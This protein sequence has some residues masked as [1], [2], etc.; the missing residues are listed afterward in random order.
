VIQI[1]HGDTHDELLKLP[2]ESVQTVVT[3]PPYLGLR[4]YGVKGQIGLEKT[5][6]DYVERLVDVFAQVGRVLRKDGTLWVNLGDAYVDGGRGNDAHTGSTLEG[7]RD[8]QVESRKTRVREGYKGLPRKN[9]LGMP[10]RVAFEMQEQGWILRSSVVWFKPNPMPESVYDRP[11]RA[12]E[13]VFLFSKNNSRPLLWRAKDTG[14]WSKRPDLNETLD[15]GGVCVRRWRG[16]DYY[17]DADA[18]R[19]PF[20][21]YED[22][23]RR[24]VAQT[25]ENK[26]MPDALKNGLRPKVYGQPHAPDAIKSPHGQGFTRRAKVPG[27][28]DTGPGSHSTLEHNTK[29]GRDKPRGHPRPQEGTLD[30]GTKYEQQMRGANKRDVW[31][32]ST[33]PYPEAH[34]ATFPEEL[35]ETCIL[36]GSKQG[37]TVLDP[38]AGSG[39]TLAVA[40]RLG[41]SAIGI[42]LNAEYV[43]LI[44]ERTKQMSLL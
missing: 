17:Y 15:V 20:K 21:D 4:D 39:T 14:E 3:S 42:E 43:K 25:S 31:T 35:P 2:A 7:T 29:A 28:W 41:R 22:D 26:S 38:F 30:V 23:L 1:I 36:A 19:T 5:P 10:W 40:Q 27:G 24:M 8:N 11:T 32:M 9:L 33:C 44:Q 37:D 12:H 16:F 34:F 6:Q 18:I 13:F